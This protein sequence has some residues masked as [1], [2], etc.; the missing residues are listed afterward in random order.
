MAFGSSSTM[1]AQQLIEHLRKNGVRTAETGTKNGY[2]NF[3]LS[4]ENAK[5][6][7]KL[8]RVHKVTIKPSKNDIPEVFLTPRTKESTKVIR[9]LNHTLRDAV[10]KTFATNANKDKKS[11]APKN[12][13]L[14]NIKST[15]LR[16]DEDPATFKASVFK[17]VKF[18]NEE[19]DQVDVE[20]FKSLAFRKDLAFIP[21]VRF[22]TGWISEDKTRGGLNCGLLALAAVTANEED[23]KANEEAE[24][25][26]EEDGEAGDEGAPRKK[27]KI[28]YEDLVN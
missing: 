9:E 26:T 2:T 21:M 11:K 28:S 24:G 12:A 23:K 15:L 10:A 6:A 7:A 5:L 17:G 18:F 13:N 25:D 27:S 20:A 3:K 16:E 1:K 19:G 4:T 8:P 22:H 14:P